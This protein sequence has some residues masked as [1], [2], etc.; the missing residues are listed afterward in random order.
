[1]AKH[2]NN[3]DLS[4]QDVARGFNL[5]MKAAEHLM[6]RCVQDALTQA[7][8][9]YWDRRAA[10]SEDCKP[11]AHEWQ[12][13]GTPAYLQ[14]LELCERIDARIAEYRQHAQET[15]ESGDEQ[16]GSHGSLASNGPNGYLE[17][18]REVVA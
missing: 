18:P 13:V 11:R 12:P 6:L 4:M 14:Q 8:A 3:S 5:T 17:T 7:S 2:N 9:K 15:R 10:E 16:S 1:M